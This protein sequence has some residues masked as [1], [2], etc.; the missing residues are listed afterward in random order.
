MLSRSTLS[1]LATLPLLAVVG[2]QVNVSDGNDDGFTK[3]EARELQGIDQD[4]N[5]ICASEGWYDDATCDDFCVLADPDC[6]VSNCPDPADPNVTYVG[7]PGA[8][9]CSQD[10]DFCANGGTMFN[11]AECGCGC[12]A[13]PPPGEECGGIAGLSCG[14]GE[15]CDY[16]LD[17]LCG[18]ADQLGT[19]A[20]IPDACPEY[21]SPVCGC[22]GNTYDNE[23]F[24]HGAGVAVASSGACGDPGLTC[25]GIA[26]EAC[27]SGLF[28]N[29]D[30]QCGIPDAQ[31]H[32]EAS[33][34]VC[35][36]IY[37]PVC[38][39]DGVTY[40]NSCEAHGAGASIAHDGGCGEP[41]P[42]CGGIAGLACAPGTFCLYSLADQCGNADQMGICAAIPEVCPD[43]YSPVCGCD[44]VTY[45]NECEANGAGQS[46]IATGVCQAMP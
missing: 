36:D 15:F 39:C 13:E 20:P 31:G 3:D 32:C 25:G 19:C 16:T 29:M 24:A 4:G 5:D 41:G 26:G 40:G 45:G 1:I 21:Y 30:F 43:V 34:E 33:P 7:E 14:D 35:P 22:D 28:C 6:P 2:C 9:I 8:L 46:I 10:I 12:I 37:M 42:T 27:P 18:A 38:G 23:C 11:S 44:G 17:S